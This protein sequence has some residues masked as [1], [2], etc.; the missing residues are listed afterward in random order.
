MIERH[1]DERAEAPVG[2]R[3]ARVDRVTRMAVPPP[4]IGDRKGGSPRVDR[5]PNGD[6]SALTL[7]GSDQA[8]GGS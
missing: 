6:P 8:E 5:M 7:W 1:P 4:R 3:R 2:R